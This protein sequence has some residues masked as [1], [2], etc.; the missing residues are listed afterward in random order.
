MR[1][2]R[3]LLLVCA[4]AG[5]L[6]VAAAG[7]GTENETETLADETAPEPV[8]EEEQLPVREKAGERLA[9]IQES[10]VLLIGISPDYA[11]FAF[12]E[13]KDGGTV[14]A[15]SDI[16]LGDYIAAELGVEARYV[17]MD[18]EECLKAAKDG[19]VDMVLLGMLEKTERKNY[20]DFTEAYYKPGRQVLLVK[21]TEA[22]AYPTLEKLSGRT[23]AAQYGSLQAQLVTEQLPESYMELTDSVTESVTLL[24][25]GQADAVALDEA[26]AEDLLDEYTELAAAGAELDY[27]AEAV[28]GGVV[29]GETELLDAVNTI[30]KDVT[31]QKLYLNWLDAAIQQAAPE[32]SSSAAQSI[33][34]PTGILFSQSGC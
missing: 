8:Q 33:S 13:E 20:V 32:H 12:K 9:E 34:A 30:L 7:C 26:V 18:F 5:L 10:G 19:T 24:L 3:A 29:K 15:G 6:A 11:P 2:T 21:K 17:E 14:C 28:V 23:V 22:A 4:L 25:S 27:T 1:R 31:E 16:M